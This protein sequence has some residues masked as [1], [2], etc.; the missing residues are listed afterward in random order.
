MVYANVAKGYR[1]GG[2]VPIVPSGEAGTA[3][4]CTA[5]LKAVDPN[6][7]ISQTRT[8]QSDSL[9]NYEL[10]T[11]T[12]WL[13]RRLTVDAAGFYIKWK[14]IQQEIL[15]SCGFQYTANA[16]AAVSK[17]GELEVR[18]RPIGTPRA[19]ARLGL[20]GREDHPSQPRVSADRGLAHLSGARL[21]RQRVG[22]I[23]DCR[24][25]PSGRW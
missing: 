22:A 15:L 7:N 19:V 23:H 16:G 11:K 21:D 13:D 1:P 5:A 9:W 10:G 25:A 2:I 17:G 20:S 12:A 3:T 18:A 8:Y 6:I 24:S 4:D 14:N